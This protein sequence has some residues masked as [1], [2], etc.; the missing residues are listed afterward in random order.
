[1]NYDEF[2][3]CIDNLKISLFERGVTHSDPTLEESLLRRYDGI[4]VLKDGRVNE[5]GSFDELMRQNG[6]FHALFTVAQ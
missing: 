4:L 6:Y 2:G 5:C 1:M 3:S